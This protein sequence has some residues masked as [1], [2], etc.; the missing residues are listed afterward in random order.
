MRGR[1]RKTWYECVKDD[2]KVL[3]SHAEWAVF[4]DM[5]R[6]F[7][8]GRTSNPMGGPVVVWLGDRP[9]DRR[10][11]GSIP[12]STNFLTNSSGQATSALV[13]LFTKR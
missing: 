11:A 10:V 6:G 13:S 2:M 5:W 1:G 8:S 12:E 7:I 9:V 3:V 4:R